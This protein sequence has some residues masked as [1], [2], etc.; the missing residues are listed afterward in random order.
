MLQLPDQE[1]SYWRASSSSKAK[2][3][4]LQKDFEV[5]VAVV[6]GGIAGLSAAYLLRKAGL[7]VAVIEKDTIGA[8]TT[9][10]TTGK[11]TSQHSL[12]YDDLT[13]SLG[14]EAAGFYGRANQATIE[15]IAKIIKTE[16]IDCQ[17]TV[18][19]NYV[20]TAEPNQVKKFKAEA[21]AAAKLGLKARF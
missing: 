1:I 2:Y 5:D 8:G 21:K 6:G 18:E 12:I 16:K 9:G 3:P 10:H 13:N 11:V 4:K 19:D 7:S 17:W 20:F 15:Q 14:V